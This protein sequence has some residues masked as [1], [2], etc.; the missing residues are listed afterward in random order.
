MKVAKGVTVNQQSSMDIKPQQ[1][2]PAQDEAQT[3]KFRE[4]FKKLTGDDMEV[5]AWELQDILNAAL[6]RVF[7]E[8]QGGGFS[9]ECC[10]SMV[11]L[12]DDDQSGKLGFEEF[13][14]LWQNIS[15]WKDVFKKYD[16]DNSGTFNGYEKRSALTSF[17]FK[18]SN[19]T[20]S[21][22]ILRYADK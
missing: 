14:E 12:T 1:P 5:D 8:L 7:N 2:L 4:F 10:K 11:A 13:R 3:A 20:F 17:G 21:A 18:L 16:A 15:A 19:E 9:L 22:L 6:K